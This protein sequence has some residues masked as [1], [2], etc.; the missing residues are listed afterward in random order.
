MVGGDIQAGVVDGDLI[1]HLELVQASP[2]AGLSDQ[3]PKDDAEAED[4]TLCGYASELVIE[5][6]RSPNSRE[7][8]G[9][10]G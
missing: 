2:R 10:Q 7:R 5:A 6:L 3:L 9:Q 1:D 8:G 4:I